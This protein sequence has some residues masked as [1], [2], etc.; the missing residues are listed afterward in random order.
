[1]FLLWHPSLTAINVSYT[2]PI[3]ETSATALCGTTGIN[4]GWTY[5]IL[6]FLHC[7][8]ISFFPT[9]STLPAARSSHRRKDLI[10]SLLNYQ[11]IGYN[12]KNWEKLTVRGTFSSFLIGR[13]T[14][15]VAWKMELQVLSQK[16]CQFHPPLPPKRR[17][18]WVV[19]DDCIDVSR[20]GFSV[21]KHCQSSS[22][23]LYLWQRWKH[24]STYSNWSCSVW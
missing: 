8:L 10:D 16:S 12:E 3:L 17:S 4:D 9:F 15:S 6:Q 24:C 5:P 7:P 20:Q 21:E 22:C 19:W 2:F 11:S 23:F 18:P 14:D 13:V 1:M